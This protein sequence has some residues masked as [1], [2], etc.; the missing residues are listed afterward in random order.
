MPLK[1]F[2]R[3]LDLNLKTSNLDNSSLYIMTNVIIYKLML[4][5]PI[6]A[7][8]TV[9]S[10]PGFEPG[11]SVWIP[12]RCNLYATTIFTTTPVGTIYGN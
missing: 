7:S 6:K 12:C 2:F 10:S 9:T 11:H 8:L 3:H 5:S 4:A 1:V